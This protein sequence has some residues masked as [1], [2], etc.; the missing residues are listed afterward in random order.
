MGSVREGPRGP[1]TPSWSLRPGRPPP[2]RNRCSLD[3]EAGRGVSAGGIKMTDARK[4][5]RVFLC[6]KRAGLVERKS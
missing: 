6:L 2:T 5:G 4:E 3:L 1:R